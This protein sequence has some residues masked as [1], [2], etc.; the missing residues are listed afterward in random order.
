MS[1]YSSPVILVRK[2]DE[3]WRFCVEY[4]TLNK[5]MVADKFPIHVIEEL[6]D[7]L[8]CARVF[9]KLDL[10]FG[11]HHI[12][13]KKEDVAKIAFRT[14]EGH[15][16]FLVMPFGLTNAPSTF[17]G[18]INRVLRPFLRRFVLVF[19]DD[20]LIYCPDMVQHVD[21]LRQVLTLLRLHQMFVN[22]KKCSLGKG[23]LE[24]LGHI[25]SGS[26]VSANPKKV[27]AMLTWPIPKD[28]KSLRG[29]L[30]LTVYY[31]YFVRGYGELAVPL[32]QLLKKDCFAWNLEAQAAF[33]ALKKAMVDLPIL[34]M[35][36]FERMIVIE[37]DASGRGVGAVLMQDGRPLAFMRNVL[38]E[39]A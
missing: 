18:L 4:R 22:A 7:E 19:F 5:V 1:P 24:Y 32:A 20:I 33:E 2:K 35:P 29:F 23:E 25:V 38:L 28:I 12:R 14:H 16:E 26:G 39:R 30:G 31:R 3:G 27:D 11:Y 21:H 17:Q 8:G 34:A 36:N 10:K 13:M 6:L 15:Y 9:T 37:S